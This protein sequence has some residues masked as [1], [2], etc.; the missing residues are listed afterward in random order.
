MQ[1]QRPYASPRAELEAGI[2][3]TKQ[4]KFRQAIPLLE[5]ARPKVQ[6]VFA[7]GFDLALCYA[8][9]GQNQQALRLLD[10]LPEA[11]A[12]ASRAEV[13]N[14]RAQVEIG[15]GDLTA[16][17]TAFDRAAALEP[18]HLPLYLFLADACL[19]HHHYALGLRVVNAGL[20]RFPRSARLYYQ[21]ANLEEDTNQPQAAARDWRKARQM[22]PGG[23]I[24]DMAAAQAALATAQ[25]PAAL[26]AAR[27][28]L[29]G[30]R[31]SILL[32]T[33]FGQAALR[34]GARPGQ[35]VFAEARK[36]LE[37]AV[38]LAPGNAAAELAL[39][40]LE[41]AAGATQA[42]I[43]HLE[44]A[45]QAAPDDPAVYASLAAA[46]RK[47]GMRPQAQAALARL[48]RINRARTNSYRSPSGSHAG[49]EGRAHQ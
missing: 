18:R 42:A 11:P 19:R 1:G 38:A 47:M 3:L 23:E 22:S 44:A 26:A 48:A 31:N 5:A 32:L 12:P 37:R 45:R 25:F 7:A 13:E 24:A 46:Y 30:R 33:I 35:A 14:L 28:G 27:H 15:L 49:Y 9:I 20:A 8:A 17:E 4:G 34:S 40:H 36:N 2:A 6:D 29:E 39:G 43:R 10:E 41:M 16:A 21:R